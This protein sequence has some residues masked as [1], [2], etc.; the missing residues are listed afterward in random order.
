MTV[1]FSGSWIKAAR[2]YAELVRLCEQAG[3]GEA[4]AGAGAPG[5]TARLPQYLRRTAEAAARTAAALAGAGGEEE[6]AALLG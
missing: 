5:L 2:A 6:A 3:S 4:V 1:V